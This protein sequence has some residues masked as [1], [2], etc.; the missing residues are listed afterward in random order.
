MAGAGAKGAADGHLHGEEHGRAHGEDLVGAASEAAAALGGKPGKQ[1]QQ[2]AQHDSARDSGNPNRAGTATRMGE[3]R[4]M[5][6]KEAAAGDDVAVPA[7]AV[8]GPGVQP[9]G[10]L[11]GLPRQTGPAS[12]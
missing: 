7:G 9:P 2:V 5:S 6:K 11:E 4:L 10:R 8:V 3:G 12:R 1:Q